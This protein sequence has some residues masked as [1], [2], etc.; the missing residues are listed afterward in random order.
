MSHTLQHP[1][2]LLK[3]P[4]FLAFWFLGWFLSWLVCYLVGWLVGRSTPTPTIISGVW[5]W[6][7]SAQ[8][9]LQVYWIHSGDF[10]FYY[11]QTYYRKNCVPFPFSSFF[12]AN[13]PS[14]WTIP[15]WRF[16]L[17]S[18]WVG[19]LFKIWTIWSCTIFRWGITE[20]GGMFLASILQKVFSSSL[21]IQPPLHSEVLGNTNWCNVS[22]RC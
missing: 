12:L 17:R 8:Q 20:E 14:Y 22:F 7:S 3:W 16:S 18:H 9:R 10:P 4:G 21:I 5:Y 15:G 6:P 1:S 11:C 19:F 2:K 13:K